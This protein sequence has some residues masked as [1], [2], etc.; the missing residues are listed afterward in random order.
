MNRW[1]KHE[2]ERDDNGRFLPVK[3]ECVACDE[4]PD[5]CDCDE[6]HF[7]AAEEIGCSYHDAEESYRFS[8]RCKSQLRDWVYDM[9]K[10]IHYGVDESLL[11]Y[12]DLDKWWADSEADYYTIEDE[13]GYFHIY[14]GY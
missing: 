2:Q 7:L 12:V 8:Y 9:I 4:E 10:D 1:I 3:I 5:I 13:D 6:T 14:E 11:W